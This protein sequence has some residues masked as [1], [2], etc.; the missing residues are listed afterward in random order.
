MLQEEL[1]IVELWIYFHLDAKGIL[2]LH[3]LSYWILSGWRLACMTSFDIT[4]YNL[5]KASSDHVWRQ[6]AITRGRMRS[7]QYTLLD[8][9]SSKVSTVLDYTLKMTENIVWIIKTV[10]L[11][12]KFTPC[13]PSRLCTLT[14][15]LP[16][17]AW[18]GCKCQIVRFWKVAE[19]EK[20]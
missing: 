12:R 17:T 19:F 9:L 11:E 20:V 13:L 14:Y 15:L 10:S 4:W 18:S 3:K 5:S 16:I 8:N 6:A 1:F 7:C 2:E